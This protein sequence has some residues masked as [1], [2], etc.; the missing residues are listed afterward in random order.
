MLYIGVMTQTIG[1]YAGSFDPLTNGHLSVIHTAARLFDTL[2]IAVGHNPAKKTMFTPE[3]RVAMIDAS[4]T[5]SRSTTIRVASFSGRYLAHVAIDHCAT[6]IV[7]GIRNAADLDAEYTQAQFNRDIAE[8]YDPFWRLD[9]IF[10]PTHPDTAHISSSAVKSLMGICTWEDI[11][12][13]Y[14]PTAVLEG[15]KK[16]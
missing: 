6:H 8:K 15:L 2:I 13:E 12:E 9:T 3:E 7:R 16:K 14:V 11:A 4:V 1:I 10:I 5:S